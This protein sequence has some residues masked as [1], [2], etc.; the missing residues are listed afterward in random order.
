MYVKTDK[1]VLKAVAKTLKQIDSIRSADISGMDQFYLD[2]ARELLT[3]VIHSNGYEI[4]DNHRIKKI[5]K[6][7][8]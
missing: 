1:A 8:S 3:K 5:S 7:Q 4:G 2:T 6:K